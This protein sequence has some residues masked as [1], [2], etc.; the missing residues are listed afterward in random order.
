MARDM[1][2]S[3]LFF[4]F[5]SSFVI[6]HYLFFLFFQYF[7]NESEKWFDARV[8]ILHANIYFRMTSFSFSCFCFPFIV[9]TKSKLNYFIAKFLI[10]SGCFP[11]FPLFPPSFP[12][13]ALVFSISHVIDR[14]LFP[15]FFLSLAMKRDLRLC[16]I[17]IW[18]HSTSSLLGKVHSRDLAE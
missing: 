7:L 11:L 6:F 2:I 4:S 1:L 5:L 17:N 10:V 18:K 13:P 16:A 3:P 14:G 9:I 15:S 8:L 12:S